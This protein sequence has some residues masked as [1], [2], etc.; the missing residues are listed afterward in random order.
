M[1]IAIDIDD[2]LTE[3]F[4]HFI[5]YVAEYFHADINDLI[6]GN[7]SYSTLPDKWKSEEINFGKTYYDQV[8]PDTPFKPDAAWA[9]SKLKEAGHTIY[10]IT[11]RTEAFYTDPYE[12]SA[13][14]LENGGIVYD[15]LIC[16]MDKGSACVSENISIL[17][18]DSPSN[19]VSAIENP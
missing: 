10:I 1:N 16:T 7:V 4:D 9:V 17:I 6:A 18:D 14:E 13:R 5:P 19:C 11:A 3:S 8:V 15:K 2:T 12:S